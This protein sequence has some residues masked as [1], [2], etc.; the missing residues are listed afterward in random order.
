MANADLRTPLH[1][2]CCEGH[3]EVVE[4]A[5]CRGAS[6]HVKDRY[7]A[8]MPQVF[9]NKSSS[10]HKISRTTLFILFTNSKRNYREFIILERKKSCSISYILELKYEF[11]KLVG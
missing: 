2:A 7:V 11:T 9:I 3:T 5:L 1:V 4:L 8:S 6:V 10:K